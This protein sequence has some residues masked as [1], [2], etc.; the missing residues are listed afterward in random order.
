MGRKPLLTNQRVLAAVQGWL[1]EHG[2]PP[3]IEQLRKV[4]K[5]GSTR[6]VF[7]YLQSLEAEGVIER[8]DAG[9]LR[10]RKPLSLGVRTK[11]VP[12][13]GEVPAGPLMVAE[14]NVEGWLRLP[15]SL[16]GSYSTKTFLLRIRGNSMNRARVGRDHIEDGDL[17]LVHQQS[18]ADN[19]DIVVALIDGQATVKSLKKKTGYWV[20]QPKST[21]AH[22]PIVVDSG[23][24]VLGV[25][26]KVLKKGS[27]IISVIEE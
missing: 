25:V 14:E 1:A 15:E 21:E 7:R 5:V 6:T 20:L 19:G 16:V 2:Y 24:R 9:S 4:L 13:V 11:A 8:D 17:V 3:S 10:I 22:G 27:D 12:L 18:T 26:A 23:F